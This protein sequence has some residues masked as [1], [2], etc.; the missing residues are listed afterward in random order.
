MAFQSLCED[1]VYS[2]SRG[3]SSINQS[4]SRGRNVGLQGIFKNLKRFYRFCLINLI[5]YP[6]Q[7]FSS[8]CEAGTEGAERAAGARGQPGAGR[9]KGQ[10]MSMAGTGRVRT[11]ARATEMGSNCFYFPNSSLSLF[12]SHFL[13]YVF[14]FCLYI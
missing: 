12:L 2:T 3:I 4:I 8:H 1:P 11:P 9:G 13:F 14:L 5:S 7:Q 6:N 10:Q